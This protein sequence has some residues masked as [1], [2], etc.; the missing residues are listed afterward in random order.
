MLA[1][2]K[3]K[4]GFRKR[5]GESLL[6]DGMI[7]DDQL[8]R[9][10]ERQHHGGGFL[11][12]ILVGLGFV[13]PEQLRPYLESVTGFSFVDMNETDLDRSLCSILP[14]G[15]AAAKM[16]LP[17]AEKDGRVLVAMADPVNVAVV[18]DLRTKLQKPIQPMLALHGDI[19]DAIRRAYDVRTR[20][21]DLLD[22]M[23]EKAEVEAD[24]MDDLA[25]EAER[26]PVVRLVAEILHSAM[27][28]GASDI[29]IEPAE[30]NV[31]VRFRVD[32]VLYEQ[33]TI[34]TNYLAAA[35]SRL[36]VMASLDIAE[37]RRP[38][39]G[40]FA[41]K[42]ERNSGYDVRLSIMPTVY[43]EKACMR[44]LEKSNE[45]AQMDRLGFLP[46]Q[47][48]LF[49]KFI[50][51]PHGLILVTGPTGSGK[52]TTLYAGLQRINNPGINISTVEDPVE[53]KLAG[54]NQTQVNP[55][56][57]VDFAT[58]LRT[59]VRQD[60]DVIL[61]GE[62]RDRATAEIAIQAALT[63]HL[64]LSSLHTNDAAGAVVRLQNMGIEPFLISSAVIGVVGQRLL[65]MVCPNCRETSLPGTDL[66]QALGIDLES[67]RAPL[68]A[69]GVGCKRCS[70]RG[71]KGRTAAMEVL[72]ITDSLRSMILKEA[73]AMELYQQALSEGLVTMKQAAMRKALDLTVPAEEIIRVFA[74]DN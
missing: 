57:G 61:V 7:G 35:V 71:M 3:P 31:R 65:R 42:D 45:L 38:Q 40:R 5:L 58:G 6:A 70:G 17:Y 33:M 49:E 55:K 28:A 52:S 15:Y 47:R 44:L 9:A 29:H 24:D 34:P 63:G 8:R 54:I 66:C 51:R 59:L 32:G 1:Q 50:K 16:V 41:V 10:L 11:G 56:I 64:V 60:P 2:L 4:K 46:E 18:D 67:G 62:I 43:G 30:H 27:A 37:R 21:K 74:E 26:A 13:S 69:R 23:F 72:P 25:N 39:D 68:L 53:Y 73:S 22:D 12:E 19:E 14:E 36:K 48:A 20:T